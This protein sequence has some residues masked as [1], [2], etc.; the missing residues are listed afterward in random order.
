MAGGGRECYSSG[1]REACRMAQAVPLK[2]VLEDNTMVS[3]PELVVPGDE[4]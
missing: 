3:A 1:A 2:K 4:G